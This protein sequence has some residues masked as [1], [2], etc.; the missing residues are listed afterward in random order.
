MS[1]NGHCLLK[2][3]QNVQLVAWIQVSVLP[4]RLIQWKKKHYIFC[5]LMIHHYFLSDFSPLIPHS[6]V[7]LRAVSFFSIFYVYVIKCSLLPFVGGFENPTARRQHYC[8]TS[9]KLKPT[10]R[11]DITITINRW[12]WIQANTEYYPLKVCRL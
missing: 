4:P 12:S 8:Y 7:H 3:M 10:M 9:V 6:S 1:T 2:S 11:R 5:G